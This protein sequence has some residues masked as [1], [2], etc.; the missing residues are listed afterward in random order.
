MESAVGKGTTFTVILPLTGED[1]EHE[2]V[3]GD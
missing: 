1:E 3:G 2:G